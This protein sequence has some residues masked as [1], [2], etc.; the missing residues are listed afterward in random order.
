M[1]ARSTE[2]KMR[3]HGEGSLLR[4]K[5]CK[6]LYA[7]FYKDGRQIR[8]STGETVHQKA[9]AVLRRLQGDSERG[10][11]SP[12]DLKKITYAGLRAALIANYV[13]R[14]N[15]SLV[16][17]ADGTESIV[18]LPQLDKFFGYEETIHQGKISVVSPGVPVAR[19]TTDASRTFAQVR[20]AEGAGPAM[21]NRSLALMRRMLR[22]AHEDNKI[23][24]VPKIRLL[25]EPPPFLE[26]DKFDEL[27]GLLPGYL[28]PLIIFL[29]WCG[30][31]KGEALAIQWEQVDLDAGVIR[32]EGDQTKNEEARIVP[33]PSVLVVQLRAVTAK[34]GP[35]FDGTNLR[36]EWEKACAACGLGTRVRVEGE[37]FIR[38]DRKR[39]RRV[40][41]AWYRYN[42]L[43]L[44]DMR[45]S[46]ISNL[47]RAGIGEQVA[48]KI[49]GHK[50]VSVFRRYN[51]VAADDV[52]GAMRHLESAVAGKPALTGETNGA[53]TVQK[54]LPAIRKSSRKAHK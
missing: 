47:T 10:L 4:R 39:P 13:E 33:L 51:I 45:R 48:M 3:A 26:Q 11:A 44:H 17:R 29:Y 42:G 52:I 9:L 46:A 1:D 20:S 14:G 41:N 38:T 35:V 40:K 6:I 27:V 5:D 24:A 7:Q 18:G 31:R 50:T 23:T 2:E 34:T 54:R 25:K 12:A 37:R 53:K 8:V 30:G 28:R 43:I 21:I 49:S 22:I 16:Q 19:L 36:V 32:L 15:K